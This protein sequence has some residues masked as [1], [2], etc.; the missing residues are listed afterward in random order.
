MVSPNSCVVRYSD[1]P[2]LP[3]TGVDAK[4]SLLPATRPRIP[5]V[6]WRQPPCGPLEATQRDYKALE[7]LT[8]P[9]WGFCDGLAGLGWAGWRLPRTTPLAFRRVHHL[10]TA[11]PSLFFCIAT[12]VVYFVFLVDHSWSKFYFVLSFYDT[13]RTRRHVTIS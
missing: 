5:P 3:L 1:P 2:E 12:L 9:H 8:G 13:N 4:N 11:S 10:P 6:I 7:E